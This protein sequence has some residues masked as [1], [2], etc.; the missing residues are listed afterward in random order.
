MTEKLISLAARMRRA[1]KHKTYCDWHQN[2]M[3]V[4]RVQERIIYLSNE[5]AAF[6]DLESRRLLRAQR[7]EAQRKRRL[8]IPPPPAPGKIAYAVYM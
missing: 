6:V 8:G 3:R 7:Q 2:E 1:F 4:I 5:E